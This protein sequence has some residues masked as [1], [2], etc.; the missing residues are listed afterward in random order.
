MRAV[1]PRT[2]ALNLGAINTAQEDK[3]GVVFRLVPLIRLEK[4]KYF[5]EDGFE[6]YALFVF[7]GATPQGSSYR[8]IRISWGST[9]LYIGRLMRR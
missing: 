9:R 7:H 4:N 8:R 5:L 6:V 2:G 3:A 1:N